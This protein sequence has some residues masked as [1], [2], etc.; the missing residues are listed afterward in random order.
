MT[1]SLS[2]EEWKVARNQARIL[3]RCFY[4]KSTTADQG[5][6]NIAFEG[7]NPGNTSDVSVN[8]I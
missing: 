1:R 7:D 5:V 3:F 2:D 6:E 4:K 8:K